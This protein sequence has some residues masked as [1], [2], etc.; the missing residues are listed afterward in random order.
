LS[1][2]ETIALASGVGGIFGTEFIFALNDLYD[3]NYSGGGHQPYGFDQITPIW[4]RYLVSAVEVEV[5][6]TN[7][8]EDGVTVGIIVQSSV[9]TYTLAL[10]QVA[11]ADENPQVRTKML[12]ATGSQVTTINFGRIPLHLLEGLTT[13]EY[14][15][16][17]DV[18]GALVST[19]P[20]RIP[21]LRV[22]LGS[23]VGS[24]TASIQALVRLKFH[25]H[26]FDRVSQTQS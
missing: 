14:K 8:N 24:A 13:P 25:A 3:P 16:Q 10:K 7:P 17:A 21:L 23:I 19:S 11:E 26:F 4:K 18:Y 5:L 22:A 20:T 2:S 1:Y 6:F 15:G 9:G 12:N